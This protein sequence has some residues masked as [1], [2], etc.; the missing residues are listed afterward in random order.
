MDSTMLAQALRAQL[1]PLYCITCEQEFLTI[2]VKH[3]ELVGYAS[4]YHYFYPHNYGHQVD[5]CYGPFAVC[6]PP[7]VPEQNT[8]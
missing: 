1:Q 3:P 8:A 7:E 2:S 6:P 4:R 5:V